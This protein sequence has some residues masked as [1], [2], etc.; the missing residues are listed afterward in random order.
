M[1]DAPPPADAGKQTAP[2]TPQGDPPAPSET[3]WQAKFEAQQKVNR[4]LETKLQGL[5]DGQDKQ[6]KALAAAL[7]VQPPEVSDVEKL[8]TQ[9]AT[10]SEQFATSQRQ[11]AVLTV[12]RE[13]GLTEQDDLDLLAKVDD[14]A[15]MTALAARL[16]KAD[17]PSAQPRAPRPDPNQGRGRESAPQ[18]PA[19]A[20]GNFLSKQLSG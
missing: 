13:H 8:A 14:P 15:A 7:G 5:R 11:N 20:F 1:P 17:P 4:D 2:S 10:L 16:A 9:I 6:T 18:T 12:A 3:D 19:Q